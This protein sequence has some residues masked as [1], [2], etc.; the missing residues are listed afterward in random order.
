M[1]S[2]GKILENY[3]K[4]LGI[5]KPIKRYTVLSIWSRVVGER[6]AE[7]TQ[8]IRFDG[9]KLFIRV[10]SAVWRH[11]LIYYKAEIIKKINRELQDRIVNDIILT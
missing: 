8:P 7:V 5:E 11:E 2:I 4:E 9:G 10:K 6:I 1:E 3:L